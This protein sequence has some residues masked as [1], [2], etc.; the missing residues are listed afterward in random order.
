MAWSKLIDMELTD[1]DKI[2]EA[3][4]S[5]GARPD[6]PFGL[7][8]CLTHKELAKLGLEP[9]CEVGDMIDLRA[10]ARVT[11]VSITQADAQNM[12]RVELQIEQ[13]SVEDEDTEGGGD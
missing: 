12:C 10:F 1:E 9:D 7:R 6:Y 5:V 2:D 8:I 13:L 11:S 3:I 4:P